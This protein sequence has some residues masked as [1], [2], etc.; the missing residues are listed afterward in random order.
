MDVATNYEQWASAA[1]AVDQ[2]DGKE[3][4]KADPVSPDYDY[5]LLQSRI[6]Q[7]R[8]AREAGDVSAMIFLLRSS[9]SRHL[10]DMGNPR[11]YA[12]THTGTKHLIEGFIDEVVQQLHMLADAEHDEWPSEDARY[13]FFVNMRHAYGRTAL[14]LSGGGTLGIS[15]IGVLRALKECSLIPRV[16][17][18]ASSGS[19]VASIICTHTDDELDALMQPVT[20]G[21]CQNFFDSFEVDGVY[22]KLKRFVTDGVFYDAESIKR[23]VRGTLGDVTFQEAF[24]RTRRVL[25]IAVSSATVF[26]MPRLLNYLTTPNVV[27]WSAVIASCAVPVVF[28]SSP[29]MVKDEKGNV[30][31]WDLGGHRWIDGSVENDLP[32]NKLSELFNINHFIVCQVNPH[33]IPFIR[34]KPVNTPW[35]RAS[36]WAM[37]LAVQEVYHRL[38]QLDDV[39]IMRSLTSRLRSIVS[40]RY[41]GD[42]TILPRIDWSRFLGLLTNPSD[43][44]I[45]EFIQ[46]GERSTWPKIPIIRNHC[47]IEMTIDE[48]IYRL[49]LR[50]LDA[51]KHTIPR[52]LVPRSAIHCHTSRPVTRPDTSDAGAPMRQQ[53]WRRSSA[54]A[55]Q[56][57]ALREEQ[58]LTSMPT[59]CVSPAEANTI[60]ADHPL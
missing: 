27:I 38:T 22:S 5:E 51:F 46:N 47:R 35:N 37:R 33:V 8:A 16:I 41:V 59:L 45:T 52:S 53:F 36:S 21:R 43:E 14:L 26:E 39:G 49:R 17:S 2:I 42:I 4:W 60:D 10:A 7:L 28:Q 18:G 20:H 3:A 15:H 24:N 31:P 19:I 6:R 13:E 34:D 48:I 32:M 23:S 9:L 40:Q 58:V 56:E 57:S 44:A 29:L 25:N 55:A 30:V 54:G 12:A 50:R 1:S 11:N